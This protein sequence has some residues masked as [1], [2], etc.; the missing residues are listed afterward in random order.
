[1]KQ[2]SWCFVHEQAVRQRHSNR[3]VRRRFARDAGADA[4]PPGNPRQPRLSTVSRAQGAANCP[5]ILW[6]ALCISC[7][8]R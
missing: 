2:H 6:M 3:A 1:V 4:K 5:Q 7:K 8:L